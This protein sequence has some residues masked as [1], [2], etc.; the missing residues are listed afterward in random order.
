MQSSTVP[1][2]LAGNRWVH[3]SPVPVHD[4]KTDAGGE[5]DPSCCHSCIR[6][7]GPKR[8]CVHKLLLSILAII[9]TSKGAN[10]MKKR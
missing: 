10:L 9:Q 6:L 1:L 2:C 5:T 4:A 8:S 7:V 3:H